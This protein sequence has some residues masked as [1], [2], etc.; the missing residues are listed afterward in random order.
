MPVGECPVRLLSMQND[1]DRGTDWIL[2]F[3]FRLAFSF[4]S[5]VTNARPAVASARPLVRMAGRGW[6]YSPLGRVGSSAMDGVGDVIWR[7]VSEGV[8][9]ATPLVSETGGLVVRSCLSCSWISISIHAPGPES[10][11]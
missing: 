5:L 11:A 2:L 4:S 10:S 6:G 1:F 8:G 3:R 9:E 7:S